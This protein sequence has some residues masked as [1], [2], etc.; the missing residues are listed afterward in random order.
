MSVVLGIDPGG[1][2]SA[3]LRYSTDAQI[4]GNMSLGPND[5]LLDVLIGHY[6][7][8]GQA[9]HMAIE[10]MRARGMP[11]AN[12]EF[13]TCVWIG[14]FIQAWQP[15]P[16]SFVYR[17]DVKMHLCGSMRAKDSNIR[18]ALIDRF[19]GSK[20]KAVGINADRG[21]LFG[22]KRDIWSALSIAVTWADLHAAK[23]SA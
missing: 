23:E 2:Q 17:G 9:D 5:R 4:V 18:A 13:L 16:W 19:G 12:A 1:E 11:T 8:S 6:N 21:P 20:R 3:W 10:M 15:R 7:T 22:I 14:R